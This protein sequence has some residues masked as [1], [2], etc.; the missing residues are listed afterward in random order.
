M[1]CCPFLAEPLSLPLFNL[2]LGYLE[3]LI[4]LLSD[5]SYLRTCCCQTDTGEDNFQQER[6]KSTFINNLL[7][8][9]GFGFYLWFDRTMKEH[10]RYKHHLCLQWSDRR[11][12][13]CTSYPNCVIIISVESSGIGHFFVESREKMYSF[14]KIYTL[15]HLDTN[16]NIVGKK[17][18]QGEKNMRKKRKEFVFLALIQV[19]AVSLTQS[20]PFH[21]RL[22]P[23]LSFS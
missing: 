20:L 8:K 21:S 10:P 9:Q 13:P 1:S 23:F 11:V 3:Q 14:N 22:F 19:R 7:Y 18:M 5:E 4:C 2:L 6:N 12:H 16:Y 15:L 17:S